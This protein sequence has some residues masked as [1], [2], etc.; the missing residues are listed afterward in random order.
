MTL[1]DKEAI[2][3]SSLR[4]ILRHM[5]NA[6]VSIEPLPGEMASWCIKVNGEPLGSVR[7]SVRRF[8]SLDS[9]HNTLGKIGVT[10]ASLKVSVPD[11]SK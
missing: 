4:A 2:T 1:F 11:N 5:P 8:A 6:Q 9:V 7:E 3:E 10:V